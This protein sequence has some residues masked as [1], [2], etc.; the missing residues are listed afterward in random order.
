[1]FI[2][3]SSKSGDF[4]QQGLEKY[5]SLGGYGTPGELVKEK[6]VF[7]KM[8]E[9]KDFLT[10]NELEFSLDYL[11]NKIYAK[12]GIDPVSFDFDINKIP[13]VRKEMDIKQLFHLK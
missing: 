10:K 5:H 12:R 11:N 2:C 4:A 9:Y 8:I 6:L 13:E 1:M 3:S 7:D